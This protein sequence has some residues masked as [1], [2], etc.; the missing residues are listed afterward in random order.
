MTETECRKR[1]ENAKEQ[2]NQL[3]MMA[4][5]DGQYD[6]AGALARARDLVADALYPDLVAIREAR[7][8]ESRT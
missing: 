4:F 1:V 6:I 3:A 2:I 7:L 5:D 8:S